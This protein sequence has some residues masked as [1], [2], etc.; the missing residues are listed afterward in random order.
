MYALYRVLTRR[1]AVFFF[2]VI[3][4]IGSKR[5]ILKVEWEDY[6]KAQNR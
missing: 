1:S 4:L 3:C 5:S 2:A 6:S